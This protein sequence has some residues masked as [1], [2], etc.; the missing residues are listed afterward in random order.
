[1]KEELII[2]PPASKILKSRKIT[3]EPGGEIGEH[4]TENKEEIII[5][6]RG[7]TTLLKEGKSVQLEQHQSHY[8]GPNI[9]HNIKNTSTSI[10]EYV[11]VVGLL[12]KDL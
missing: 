3:L 10:L 2:K 1:M 11:Y 5:V 7:T 8:I 9:K 4:I 12:S 6:L